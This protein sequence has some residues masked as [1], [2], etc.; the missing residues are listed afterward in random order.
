MKLIRII[1]LDRDVDEQHPPYFD[2][3]AGVDVP[4]IG[5]EVIIQDWVPG[6]GPCGPE[7]QKTVAGIRLLFE[8][9]VKP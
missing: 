3:P 9:E 4:A 2:L 8:P 1:D 6:L 7:L 5:D